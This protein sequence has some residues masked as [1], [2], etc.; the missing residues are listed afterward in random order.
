M[1]QTQ[2]LTV[3]DVAKILAVSVSGV[4]DKASKESDFPKPF[5]LSPRQ[6]RWKL[7]DVDV[8]IDLKAGIPPVH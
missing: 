4:W 6:A 2:L 8:Y 1:Q 5:K 3:Q 7:S